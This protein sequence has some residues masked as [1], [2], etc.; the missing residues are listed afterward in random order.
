MLDCS[1]LLVK[2]KITDP[3]HRPVVVLRQDRQRE[4]NITV[5]IQ[6]FCSRQALYSRGVTIR[7]WQAKNKKVG[8]EIS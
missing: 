4:L 6:R 1:R 8:V 2:P 5:K 7:L 3:M